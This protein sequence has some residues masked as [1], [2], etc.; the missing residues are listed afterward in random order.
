LFTVLLGAPGAGKGTQAAVISQRL[1][2]PHLASGDLF[3]QAVQ[4]GTKLGQ[5]VKEYMDKG[6]LV[7]DELTIQ[8]ISERLGEPD[9]K[10]GCLLDGFPRTVEQAKA[11]DKALAERGKAIDVGIYI[12]VAEQ[13]L[14]KRLSGR[15]I[16]R[17]CQAPY[18]EV[19]SPPKV[20][21]KCD[22]C[23]GELY[24]RSDDAEATVRERLKVYF[25][26]TTPVLGYYQ[27]Q[28]KLV[29]VDGEQEIEKVS[30]DMI[31]VLDSRSGKAK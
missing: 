8:V 30:K 29:K 23:G 15:W 24:Q 2:L 22:R 13:E 6:K 26:Q 9:C 11:L 25:A 12:E 27:K 21:G 14:L 28:G 19:S 10:D 7:P 1:K 3:R 4:K 18:H 20:A 16:C 17:Q 5:T 31:K